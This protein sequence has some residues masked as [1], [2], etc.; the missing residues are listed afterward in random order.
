[1]V[2]GRERAIRKIGRRAGETAFGSLSP[3]IC[4]NNKNEPRVLIGPCKLLRDDR[5]TTAWLAHGL[6]LMRE[7]I[8]G[9]NGQTHLANRVLSRYEGIVGLI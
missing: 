6:T 1:M 9:H 8:G 7:A 4:H 3:T 2:E 5:L